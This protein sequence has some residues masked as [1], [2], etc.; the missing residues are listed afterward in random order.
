MT[1]LIDRFTRANEESLARLG[2]M[3][4]AMVANEKCRSDFIFQIP[5]TPADGRFLN[6]QGLRRA[7]KTPML[8]C[9]NSI[10]KMAEFDLQW[11]ASFSLG[12][13]LLNDVTGRPTAVLEDQIT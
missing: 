8:S 3:N 11:P 4:A 9:G 2:E 5:D 13:G 10:A 7:P 6:L 1:N 12:P